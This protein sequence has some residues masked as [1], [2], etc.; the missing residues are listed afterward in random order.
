MR[1]VQLFITNTHIL[2]SLNPTKSSM[3][4]VYTLLTAFLIKNAR[5]RQKETEK[6]NI[7]IKA[8]IYIKYITQKQV[9]S[10]LTLEVLSIISK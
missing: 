2:Y 7:Y 3:A 5:I 1:K 9:R 8:T 10:F 4:F 6:F